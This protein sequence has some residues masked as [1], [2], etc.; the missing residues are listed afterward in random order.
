[1]SGDTGMWELELPG[2]VGR[3]APIGGNGDLAVDAAVDGPWAEVFGL[4]GS[5]RDGDACVDCMRR[6]GN[7]EALAVGGVGTALSA[8]D[9]GGG[10]VVVGTGE[11]ENV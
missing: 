1:M 8:E 9:L 3:V 2:D 10:D 5:A 6:T 7:G 4:V 11:S